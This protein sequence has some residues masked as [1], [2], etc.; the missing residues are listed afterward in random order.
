[1]KDELPSTRLLHKSPPDPP[2]Q[3][4]WSN[5]HRWDIG[6]DECHPTK[7]HLACSDH[8]RLDDEFVSQ[9]QEEECRYGEVGR[10]ELDDLVAI[11]FWEGVWV[12]NVYAGVR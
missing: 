12:E 7:V 1:M 10:D 8:G 11:V 5:L 3:I 6:I 2:K 9:D 4:V